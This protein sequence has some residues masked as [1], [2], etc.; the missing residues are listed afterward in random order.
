[1]KKIIIIFLIVLTISVLYFGHSIKTAIEDKE[2]VQKI[3]VKVENV[4][5]EKGKIIS[6]EEVKETIDDATVKVEGFAKDIADETKKIME[7]EE[8]KSFYSKFSNSVVEFG[9]NVHENVSNFYETH[10]NK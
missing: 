3:T 7:K 2:T 9:K 1:M 10:K 6:K 8:V 5:D 4:V